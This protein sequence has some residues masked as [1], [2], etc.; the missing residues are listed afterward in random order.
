MA[1]NHRVQGV[2]D[3]PMSRWRVAEHTHTRSQ[4]QPGGWCAVAFVLLL[5]KHTRR[6]LDVLRTHTFHSSHVQM[7]S[8]RE[9]SSTCGEFT[10]GESQ[11]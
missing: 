5:T 11:R 1:Q 10:N 8:R 3:Q 4:A 6:V 7:A 9:K 2:Y